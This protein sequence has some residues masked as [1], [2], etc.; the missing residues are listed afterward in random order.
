MSREIPSKKAERVLVDLSDDKAKYLMGW[1]GYRNA[2][3]KSG[4][5]YFETQTE[6]AHM[7]GTMIR[8]MVVGDA[9]TRNPIF[10]F[11]MFFVG[12]IY[13][14]P[15]LLALPDILAGRGAGLYILLINPS[16]IVGLLI[17]RNI[18]LAV[19]GQSV[20]DDGGS[21]E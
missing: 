18:Y 16:W 15:V 8:M 12:M 1:P 17:F 9:I 7:Q 13:S 3:G 6:W 4:L 19:F 11:F 14:L 20:E 21:E 5:G 2:D 10:L